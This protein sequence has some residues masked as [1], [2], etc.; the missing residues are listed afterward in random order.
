MERLIVIVL[1]CLVF[2]VGYA[3]G[4]R[5][6]GSSSRLGREEISGAAEVRGFGSAGVGE[7]VRGRSGAE[8]LELFRGYEGDED[9]QHTLVAEWV[10]MDP[11]GGVQ[12]ALDLRVPELAWKLL[13]R[14]AQTDWHATLNLAERIEVTSGIEGKFREEFCE[15][16]L[17]SALNEGVRDFDELFELLVSRFGYRPRSASI[18]FDFE[19]QEPEYFARMIQDIPAN[20]LKAGLAHS[21]V[22]RWAE[23]DPEAA[24]AWV[25]RNIAGSK[26]NVV[27]GTLFWAWAAED[28]GA[29][30]ERLTADGMATDDYS[31]VVRGFAL[32]GA[33]ADADFI[34]QWL[35]EMHVE[36]GQEKSIF[37]N[38]ARVLTGELDGDHPRYEEI[39]RATK[40]AL[41]E[42]GFRDE[43]RRGGL[44]FSDAEAL[45]SWFSA[46][47]PDDP[48]PYL[49]DSEL[50][51]HV[52][53]LAGVIEEVIQETPEKING[54]LTG[55]VAAAWATEDPVAAI[56][57][58][59]SLP[60]ALQ[61]ETAEAALGRW[62]A[63]SPDKAMA[64][65]T[66]LPESD[67]Q[68]LALKKVASSWV[69]TDVAGVVGWIDQL[70]P[71]KGHD[72]A[73]A[74]VVGQLRFSETAL[75][76]EQAQRIGDSGLRGESLA[77]V[78][79]IWKRSDEREAREA[80]RRSSL[81]AD[82][83]ALILA[84]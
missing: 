76:F 23:Q 52:G 70:S 34:A 15:T 14:W 9:A 37:S 63:L 17:T 44:P 29:A 48:V 75:A 81:K 16:V 56:E 53:I 72:S 32:G 21:I 69:Q 11:E 51:Q 8:Y 80:I 2:V 73:I 10:A 67:F 43:A 61:I 6:W 31:W 19:A 54:D 30:L 33:E 39:R 5:E 27:L 74:T 38:Q 82:E 24:L 35:M 26:R 78:Y 79:E 62:M 50:A 77:K 49:G 40:R 42:A 41:E 46:R 68:V 3:L 71:S 60:S 1:S 45:R 55:G 28:T 64:F 47:D 59:A 66:S 65:V 36:S 25:L 57:W 18:A 13:A 22:D 84:D 4:S 83:K 20:D 58:A 12:R 7:M